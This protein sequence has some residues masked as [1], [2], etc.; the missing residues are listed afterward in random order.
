MEPRAT[1]PRR[2]ETSVCDAFIE[3]QPFALLS[4]K[5]SVDGRNQAFRVD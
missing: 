2:L 5:V 3:K 4:L 1:R